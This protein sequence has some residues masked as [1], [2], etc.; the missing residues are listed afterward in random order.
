MEGSPIHIVNGKLGYVIYPDKDRDSGCNENKAIHLVQ[1][2]S[3][4]K[5]SNWKAEGAYNVV[6]ISKTLLLKLI[7]MNRTHH[8]L[9]FATS[10][11]VRN[12]FPLDFED[13]GIKDTKRKLKVYIFMFKCKSRVF[14][15]NNILFFRIFPKY[16]ITYL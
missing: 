11:G 4:Y 3:A 10:P 1:Y 14:Y 2:H 8:N 7:A 13:T 6:T 5:S 16:R 12:P 15:E 9:K